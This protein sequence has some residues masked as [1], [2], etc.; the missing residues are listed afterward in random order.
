MQR[1]TRTSPFPLLTHACGSGI[2]NCHTKPCSLLAFSSNGPR[3]FARRLAEC[4][5]ADGRDSPVILFSTHRTS[6][7]R[8]FGRSDARKRSED[9]TALIRQRYTAR[10]DREDRE[11]SHKR[12]RDRDRDREK[13]RERERD[14]KN[15]LRESC[16]SA[17]L[18][19]SREAGQLDAARAWL[20][21]VCLCPCPYT[22]TFE[23]A[24]CRPTSWAGQV[25]MSHAK[26][27]APPRRVQL[28]NEACLLPGSQG[29]KRVGARVRP[30][31]RPECVS[32]KPDL[33]PSFLNIAALSANSTTCARR[34]RYSFR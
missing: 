16:G 5:R 9:A 33:P 2:I 24:I 31:R 4:E 29:G 26:S 19:V 22:G 10:S 20:A 15:R 3:V 21:F 23:Y 32:I 27:Y 12:E 13:E 11:N 17:R 30:R 34:A 28:E 6:N 1:V 8:T 18:R 14:R 7:E 25:N